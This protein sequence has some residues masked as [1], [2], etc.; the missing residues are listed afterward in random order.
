[1]MFQTGSVTHSYGPSACQNLH[2][3]FP[4]ELSTEKNSFR[5]E[6]S[7]ADIHGRQVANSPSTG[8][9]S[10]DPLD[11]AKRILAG[12]SSVSRNKTMPL[13]L[14]D[15]MS[16]IDIKTKSENDGELAIRIGEREIYRSASSLLGNQE[17]RV[18]S[19]AIVNIPPIFSIDLKVGPDAVRFE[20]ELIQTRISTLK[21]LPWARGR[22]EEFKT[23]SRHGGRKAYKCS[24]DQV[25]MM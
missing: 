2:R 16:D 18:H 23:E 11:P 3:A 5:R 4:P 1:M 6:T 24:V 13:N 12:G 25:Y 7:L 10:G 14:V 22:K 21:G 20:S 8:W 9:A 15:T 17:S 19:F